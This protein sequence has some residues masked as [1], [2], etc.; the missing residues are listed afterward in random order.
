[1]EINMKHDPMHCIKMQRRFLCLGYILQQP[2]VRS[3]RQCVL[4]LG[5][6]LGVGC[7]DEV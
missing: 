1:M 6:C 4:K 5:L 3:V 7:N 2:N